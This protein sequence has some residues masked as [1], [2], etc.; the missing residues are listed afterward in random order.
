MEQ[1]NKRTTKA[2]YNTGKR[3][4]E[5]TRVKEMC[6]RTKAEGLRQGST[7]K[8]ERKSDD[9]YNWMGPLELD[10]FILSD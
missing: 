5:E 2:K 6:T 4:K 7:P 3:A 10:D 8:I 9:C 1:T